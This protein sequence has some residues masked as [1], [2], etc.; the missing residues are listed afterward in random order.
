MIKIWNE[1]FWKN[2]PAGE[3]QPDRKVPWL[4]TAPAVALAACTVMFGLFPGVFMD[5]SLRAAAQ[6]MDPSAYI[7]AVLQAPNPAEAPQ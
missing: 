7:E 3:R 6:L 5:Y 4:M 2:A 1:A